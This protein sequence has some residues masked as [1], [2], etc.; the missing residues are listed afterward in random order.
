MKYIN[1]KSKSNQ[2]ANLNVNKLS[3]V[4]IWS[5]WPQVRAMSPSREIAAHLTFPLC[6]LVTIIIYHLKVYILAK[7]TFQA[8]KVGVKSAYYGFNKF[9]RQINVNCKNGSNF[10]V[11]IWYFYVFIWHL[12][13]AYWTEL[14]ERKWAML[15]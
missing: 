8:K 7:S 11:K 12:V 6:S 13:N 3:W 4:I 14:G 15:S 5:T 1:K 9:S 10:G 2:N